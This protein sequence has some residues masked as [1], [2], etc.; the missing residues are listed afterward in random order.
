MCKR[1][2]KRGRLKV[3]E[4][5]NFQTECGST[6]TNTHEH[7]FRLITNDLRTEIRTISTQQLRNYS[8]VANICIKLTLPTLDA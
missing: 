8:F 2:S 3:R 4:D 7:T 1:C 6:I 5:F